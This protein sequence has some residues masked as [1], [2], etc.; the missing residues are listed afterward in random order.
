MKWTSNQ[1][2]RKTT[3][4]NRFTHQLVTFETNN[5]L[6]FGV[7]SS[8]FPLHLLIWFTQLCFLFCIIFFKWRKIWSKCIQLFFYFQSENGRTK[9]N[10]TCHL[11]LIGFFVAL[12]VFVLRN[13]KIY[14]YLYNKI[15]ALYSRISFV[16]TNW[17]KRHNKRKEINI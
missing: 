3:T 11:L 12:S 13:I 14:M 16:P 7:F 17:F 8:F 9:C 6:T 1:E 4:T 2:W 15:D 10:K 5:H